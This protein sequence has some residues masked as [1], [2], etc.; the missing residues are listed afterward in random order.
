MIVKLRDARAATIARLEEVAIRT[1]DP[2]RKAA[3]ISAAARLRDDSTSEEACD[4][5]DHYFGES[6]DWAVI[7]D[8]RLSVGTHAFKLNH[9]LINDSLEC[10]CLDTP[11]ASVR[12]YILTNPSLR[13]IA[14]MP[15]GYSS[16]NSV[17]VETADALFPLLWKRNMKWS[18]TRFER[19]TP[20]A[21]RKIAERLANQHQPNFSEALLQHNADDQTGELMEGKNPTI[22]AIAADLALRRLS[23]A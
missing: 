3:C 19:M 11:R 21:L 16:R 4:L 7:H 13:S 1:G 20:D 9:V 12:G 10:V 8:L 17:S 15:A 23:G 5:I 18:K 14:A 2:V 22:S 6:E